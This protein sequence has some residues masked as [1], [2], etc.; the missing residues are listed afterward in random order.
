MGIDKDYIEQSI[1]ITNQQQCDFVAVVTFDYGNKEYSVLQ[2]NR[3]SMVKVERLNMGGL[4]SGDYQVMQ[5]ALAHTYGSG[6]KDSCDNASRCISDLLYGLE[7]DY[8]IA[9]TMQSVRQVIDFVASETGIPVTFDQDYTTI[10]DEYSEGNTVYMDG[11]EAF[12]FIRARQTVEDGTN[13]S[14]MHRQR[15]FMDTFLSYMKDD[16]NN[17]KDLNYVELYKNLNEDI[18]EESSEYPRYLIYSN[19]SASVMSSLFRDIR[20]FNMIDNEIKTPAG[21]IDYTKKYVEFYID[22][23]SLDN[24][25]ID[26]YFT[27]TK[28]TN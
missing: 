27:K 20:V 7:I 6:L 9:F 10:D 3:D 11:E 2:F 23:D 14:R 5:L 18:K 12:R 8:Y 21:E 24:L 13:I 28:A 1:G 22:N 17:T 15:L 4:R 19:C 25:A 26:L 16:E